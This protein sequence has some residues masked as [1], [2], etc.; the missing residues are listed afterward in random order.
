MDKNKK[1]MLY[2]I[3]CYKHRFIKAFTSKNL[4]SSVELAIL[5]V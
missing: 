1:K 4:V 2:N 3:K 5:K